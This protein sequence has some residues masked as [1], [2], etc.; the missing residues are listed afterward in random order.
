MVVLEL[1]TAITS[2]AAQ[3]LYESLE[4]QRGAG[5]S[6]GS[7]SNLSER[8]RLELWYSGRYIIGANGVHPF[9]GDGITL[10]HRHTGIGVKH[11]GASATAPGEEAE[12]MVFADGLC[13][14][15]GVGVRQT[16][17]HAAIRIQHA[18][19]SCDENQYAGLHSHFSRLSA[20]FLA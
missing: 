11:L 7:H 3:R 17:G 14:G 10:L 15:W 13:T 9:G 8:C 20:S 16:I 18:D 1:G 6:T 2:V 19:P 5:I 12:K 4:W